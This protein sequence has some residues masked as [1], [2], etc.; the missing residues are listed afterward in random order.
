MIKLIK[1]VLSLIWK[2]LTSHRMK[3]LYW[4]SAMMAASF[5]VSFAIE[6]LGEFNI[7]IEY[8]ALAGLILGEISKAINNKLTASRLMRAKNKK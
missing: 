3:S 1:K 7:P 4:R 2:F 6:H 8:M 5:A